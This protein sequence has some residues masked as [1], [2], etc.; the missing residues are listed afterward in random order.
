[1]VTLYGISNCDTVR[2]ARAWLDGHGVSYQFHDFKRSGL[3]EP[4]VQGWVAELGWETLV[5]RRGTTWRGLPEPERD[6]ID[7]ESAIRL[8]V[9]HPS[10]IRRPVL[11]TGEARHVGFSESRYQELFP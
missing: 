1:M 9:E 6:R 3:D 5:N 10:L 7:E 4:Q 2:K 8:M 11:D